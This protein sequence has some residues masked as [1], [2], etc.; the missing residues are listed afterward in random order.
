MQKQDK[1]QKTKMVKLL[2]LINGA[3]QVVDYGVPSKA[4][5][6]AAMGYMIEQEVKI[7]EI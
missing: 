2:K 4:A 5:V 1:C 3:W 6:Y 7:K